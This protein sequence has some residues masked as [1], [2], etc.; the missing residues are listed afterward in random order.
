MRKNDLGLFILGGAASA[1]IA[2]STPARAAAEARYDFNQPGQ[3]LAAGIRAIALTS[4][5]DIVAPANLIGS[6]SAPPVQGRL[7][8]EQALEKVL[9]DTGLQVVAAGGTLVVAGGG[10]ES[11]A[12]PPGNDIVVTGTRIRGATVASEVIQLGRNDLLD[13]GKS[14]VADALRALPQNFGGG[15]NPGIGFNVP[16]ANGADVGGGASVNLRGLGSD[17]TLTLLNGRRLSYSAARQSVDIS[18]IPFNAIARIDVVPDGASALFGSDAVAGVVNVVLRRDLDGLEASVRLGGSTD[19]GNFNQQYSLTAGR[20]WSGGGIL[21]AYEYGANARITSG[22]RS[23]GAT[24]PGLTLYP[25]L[26]HH[27]VALSSHQDLTSGLSFSLDGLFDKRGTDHSYP[28]NLAGDLAISRTD[29]FSVARSFG[30][31]PTLTLRLPNDWQATL[32]GTYGQDKVDYGGTTYAGA[33]GSDAGSGFYRNRAANIEISGNGSLFEIAGRSAKLALG[34]GYRRNGFERF[35]SNGSQN[36]DQAQRSFYAFGELNLPLLKRGGENNADLVTAT[37][38]LRYERYPDIASVTTPKLGLIVAPS[39]DFAVKGS[40]GRSFRAPTLYQQYSPRAAYLIA[41]RSLGGGD[42]A[43]GATAILLTG[44]NIDLKPERSSNWSTT[45]DAHPRALPGFAL[46]LSYFA[47]KYTDRIVTP[48]PF[49]SIALSDPLYASRVTLAPEAATQATFIGSAG[50]F[51]NITGG[52]A[53]D[54]SRVFAL[55]D[56]S[57]VN[58][59]EQQV[60]GLDALATYHA[61]IGTSQLSLSGNASYLRSSQRITAAQP[62][63]QLAGI[64]FNPPHFRGYG[65]A[66]WKTGSLT[67]TLGAAY[68]GAVRD[69]RAPAP[70]RIDGMTPVDLTIRYQRAAGRRPFDGIDVTLSAQ[71]AF[72]AKPAVIATSLFY[73]TPYDS[74]NYTPFGRVLSVTVARKW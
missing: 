12:A 15:Q 54:A 49:L 5:R 26:S 23:Y 34:G 47:V 16:E 53:Y 61:T 41:A 4:G 11:G 14:T 64:L 27:A 7:T 6:K 28:L 60:H 29:A 71:N 44:G 51:T 9:A 48:V 31:S 13:A 24:R 2:G 52:P 1:L 70:V 35:T 18:S 38:A 73:D 72:N 46:S 30:L 66:S 8:V 57:S 67:V 20:T 40:W 68:I 25:R 69:T 17:A 22:E 19:G 58:A 45:L 36:I 37:A 65:A 56:D 33:V 32:A 3:S 39:A 42:A 63:T 74:T 55:V 62:R 21:L 43:A 59:G 10:S 50:S